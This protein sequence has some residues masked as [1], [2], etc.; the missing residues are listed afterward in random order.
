MKKKI[1]SL[2]LAMALIL[3]YTVPVAATEVTETETTPIV[4]TE[5]L[6]PKATEGTVSDDPELQKAYDC[7]IAVETAF[8]NRDYA[9]LETA[10]KAITDGDP[11]GD[12]TDEQQDEFNKIIEDNIG[13]DRYLVIYFSTAYVIATEETHQTFLADK[14]YGTAYEFVAAYDLLKADFEVDLAEFVPSAAAD[15]E[16]AKTNHLPAENIVKVYDA[17]VNLTDALE[18]AY[19]D[20]DFIEACEDFEAILDD[21]NALNEAELAEL[22]KLMGVEDGERAWSMIFSDWA[23]ACT[24]L[25][26]GVV[27]EAY[28]D[29]ENK[30]TA[31]AY[32]EEYERVF[33]SK[34]FFT[35]E[36]FELFREFFPDIDYL[37]EGAQALLTPKDIP[38]NNKTDDEKSPA[39]GDDFNAAPYVI[40]MFIAAAG[41]CLTVRRKRA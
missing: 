39:T 21:F 26:I 33:L 7:F 38:D 15:Y 5:D 32:V 16:D 19:Y 1:L 34:G 13:Y 20:S 6:Q 14:N 18:M 17:Y 40:V 3:S 24:I 23:N 28:K 31:K 30:E 37:Y 10:Y 29:N 35:D 12:W 25:E 27:Y 9:A 2:V 36:D 22:A 4:V 8:N 11:F 41:A